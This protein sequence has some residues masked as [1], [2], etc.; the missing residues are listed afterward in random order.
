V[1]G[2]GNPGSERKRAKIPETGLGFL[3]PFKKSY[4]WRRKR[5][6]LGGKKYLKK[7]HRGGVKKR[8]TLG[9]KN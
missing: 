3:I 7:G 9:K 2:K 5:S 8:K 4:L 1:T 6:N